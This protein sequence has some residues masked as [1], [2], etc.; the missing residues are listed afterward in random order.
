MTDTRHRQPAS[1]DAP[2]AIPEDSAVLAPPRQQ[3]MPEPADSESKNRQRRLVHGHS[4]VTKVSTHN[5][6]QPLAL[7]GDGFVHSSLK[8][9]FHLIQLR[10][11]PFPYR[12]P[13]HRD[14]CRLP[15]S[16]GVPEQFSYAAE[17]PARTSPV[18]ASTP[19]SRA[20]PH[21]SR[22]KWVANPLSYDFCIHYNLAGLAGA[23]ER[24]IMTALKSVSICL[25]AFVISV[26]S[27]CAN[28]STKAPDVTPSIRPSIKLG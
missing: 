14:R 9:G 10:L 11:Q 16:V 2:H 3:A 7:F 6:P 18:N 27:G 23:Q 28:N 19:P 21:D 26:A 25:I 13:Q 15:G 24:K 1:D 5:R 22:P 8:L 12:L 4:V 20:A 17:Y